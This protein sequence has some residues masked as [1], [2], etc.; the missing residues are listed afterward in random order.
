M[1][2][3]YYMLDTDFYMSYLIQSYRNPLQW[4]Y[5]YFIVTDNQ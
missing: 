4:C 3:A 2:G 1:S 5:P